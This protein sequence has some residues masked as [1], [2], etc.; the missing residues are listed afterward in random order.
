MSHHCHIRG[1]FQEYFAGG[2]DELFP[3]IGPT[4]DFGRLPVGYHG[5]VANVPWHYEIRSDTPD[6]VAV[7]FSVTTVRTPFRLD[8]TL[9]LHRHAVQLDVRESAVNEGGV[10]VA[11][12]W[13]HHLTLGPPFLSRD[14]VLD[15]GGRRVAAFAADA[16]ENGRLLQADQQGSWPH[17]RERNDKNVDLRDVL[18]HSARVSDVFYISEFDQPAWC[19]VTN[20][21]TAIGLALTWSGATLPYALIWQGFGGDQAAPWWGRASTQAIEPISN[22][23]MDFAE[24][25]RSGSAPRLGPGHSIDLE[26]CVLCLRVAFLHSPFRAPSVSPR[27]K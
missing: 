17:L 7:K 18:A 23:P 11:F 22:C 19:A 12:A 13:G 3:I 5:E 27:V 20:Q 14:C 9:S 1:T 15:T 8:R 6:K 25:V 26:M 2:W 21:A 10:P 4:T 16:Y 24:A